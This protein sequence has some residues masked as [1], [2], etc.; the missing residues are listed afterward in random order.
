MHISKFL[1]LQNKKQIRIYE[2]K[3]RHTTHAFVTVKLE[4]DLNFIS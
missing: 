4:D 2:I 3:K 1:F